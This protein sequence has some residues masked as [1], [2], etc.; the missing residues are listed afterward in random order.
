MAKPEPELPNYRC[1]SFFGR[2]SNGQHICV[3]SNDVQRRGLYYKVRPKGGDWSDQKNFF[4]GENRN[5]Y[6]TLIEDQPGEWIAVWD[7]SNSAD[8]NRTAIRF[9]RLR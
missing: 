6:P 3:Y 1:K 9:G 7:S 2:D 8:N 4:V 5:S